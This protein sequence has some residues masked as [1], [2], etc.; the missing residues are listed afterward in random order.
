MSSI[1]ALDIDDFCSINL[2]MYYPARRYTV[3]LPLRLNIG[4]SIGY[5]DPDLRVFADR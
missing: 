5:P 1:T 4:R 3:L 2:Y